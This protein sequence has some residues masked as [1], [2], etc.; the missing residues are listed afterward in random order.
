ML[1]QTLI[2]V[3]SPVYERFVERFSTIA[4]V[5]DS[6]EDEL[7]NALKGLG[8]YR[9]FRHFHQAAQILKSNPWP[10]TI[11]GLRALPGVGEYIAAAVGSIAFDIPQA[12]LDGNVQRVLCRLFAINL[13]VNDRSLMNWYRS[14]GQALVSQEQPGDFNQGMMELGQHV[15]TVHAPKCNLCPVRSLCASYANA[16]QGT[17]P[18]PKLRPEAE[19]VTL[20][21]GIVLHRG[22]IGLCTRPPT[23]RFLKG[24]PGFPTAEKG[25]DKGAAI[26]SFSHSITKHRL[27]V[28]VVRGVKEP[29]Q[30]YD[31]VAPADI[32]H[33]LISSLD[34]K[35][36]RIF[37]AH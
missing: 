37:T 18:L 25:P 27:T 19:K 8:Y 1:Q 2:K 22:K 4:A 5:A 3:V 21:L 36:W 32:P 12:V 26:G 17:C 33:R 24:I 23:A 30:T 28:H 11:A 14:I 35:A 7:K 34:L 13:P 6:S 20:Q 9:R 10:T 16:S 31:W 29:D 15:C